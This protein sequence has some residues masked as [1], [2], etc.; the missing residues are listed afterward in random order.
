M[1][2]QLPAAEN[3]PNIG[4]KAPEFTL[5]DQHGSQVSLTDLISAGPQG[6]GR[7]ALLIFYRGYW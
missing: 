2:R 1:A 5:A 6:N 3:A 7:G 4:S